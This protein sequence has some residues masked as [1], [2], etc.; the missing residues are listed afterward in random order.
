MRILLHEGTDP[1]LAGI[2][3]ARHASPTL[4]RCGPLRAAD[5]HEEDYA[6][7]YSQTDLGRDRPDRGLKGH[8][9]LRIG[10]EGGT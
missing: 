3:P 4:T 7:G 2:D 9:G 10:Q 5:S 8:D 1:R 6:A